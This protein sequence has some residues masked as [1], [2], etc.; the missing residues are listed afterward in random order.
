MS[1]IKRQASSCLFA[2]APFIEQILSRHVSEEDWLQAAS[3]SDEEDWTDIDEASFSSLGTDIQQVIKLAKELDTTH[4][5]KRDAL[6]KIVREKQ[7]LIN[8]KVLVFSSFR[9][10]LRYL[11]QHLRIRGR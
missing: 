7:E 5:P 6:L 9:H 2:L 1:T 4:D 11:K 8:K 3:D 10:T